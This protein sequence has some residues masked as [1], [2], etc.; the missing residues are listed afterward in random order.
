MLQQVAEKVKEK[1]HQN[2]MAIRIKTDIFAKFGEI[3]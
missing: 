3:H 2:T 1:K